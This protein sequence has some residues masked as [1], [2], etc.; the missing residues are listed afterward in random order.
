VAVPVLAAA[1]TWRL[2]VKHAP[3]QAWR[4][5]QAALVPP[6]CS[7]MARSAL[8]LGLRRALAA[9]TLVPPP[10]WPALLAALPLRALPQESLPAASYPS[11]LPALSAARASRPG[12]AML[13]RPAWRLRSAQ[14]S[15]SRAWSR[16]KARLRQAPLQWARAALPAWRRATMMTAAHPAA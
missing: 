4:E 14:V 9:K 10:V 6:A 12:H 5:P 1:P 13:A 3:V 15:P 2:A 7:G 16:P 8:W 11:S